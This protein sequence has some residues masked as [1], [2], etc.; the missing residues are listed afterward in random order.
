MDDLAKGGAVGTRGAELGSGVF[1]CHRRCCPGADPMVGGRGGG[2]VGGKAE[3]EQREQE[4]R[5]SSG[6]RG[7][8]RPYLDWFDVPSYRCF[9]EARALTYSG[10]D[11]EWR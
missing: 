3:G 7:H 9:V 6:F 5:K 10:G 2:D 8:D 1:G 4:E 11:A